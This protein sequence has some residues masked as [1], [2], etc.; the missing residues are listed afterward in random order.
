MTKKEMV[1]K[2][3]QRL[4]LSQDLINRVYD[5]AVK[6]IVEELK[7]RDRAIL[8]GIGSLVLTKTTP[9]KFVLPDGTTGRSKPRKTVRINPSSKLIEKL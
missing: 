4:N 1:R 5:E 7:N 6:V 8:P 2:I 3:G 9:R